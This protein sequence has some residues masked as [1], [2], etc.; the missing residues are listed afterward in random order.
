MMITAT[1]NIGIGATTPTHKLEV[2]AATDP[3]YLEGVQSGAGTDSLL[4]IENGVV[5]KIA[6]S[7]MPASPTNIWSTNGNAGTTSTTNF[8]GTTDNASLRFRT[9]NTQRMVIDSLGNVG[10]GTAAPGNIMEVNAGTAGASG[11]RLKQVPEGAILYTNASGD[12]VQNTSALY[13]DGANGRMSLSAG[14][15]PSS[16]LTNGGSM[17]LPITTKNTNY[18]LTDANYTVLCNSVAG[19][20]T[21]NLPAASSCAGRVY[22]I[23]KASTDG[24]LIILHAASGTDNIDGSANQYLYAG[25]SYFTLQSDGVSSWSIIAQH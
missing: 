6:Q 25:Y 22:V 12:L 3:L 7:A 16:T 4:V 13:Y 9:A 15:T 24:N 18:T 2:V 1:G 17:A 14:T 21:I 23:K 5:K 19:G 20:F 10:I 11:L 8:I